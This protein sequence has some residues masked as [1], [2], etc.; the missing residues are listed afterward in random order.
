MTCFCQEIMKLSTSL[1]CWIF[2]LGFGLWM[3]V[4]LVEGGGSPL[5]PVTEESTMS[6]NRQVIIQ[7]GHEN[8]KTITQQGEHLELRLE[9]DGDHNMAEVQQS[10]NHN[11]AVSIQEGGENSSRI[12]QQGSGNRATITQGGKRLADP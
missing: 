9:Q 12:R 7:H 11:Q 10:G 2:S 1:C 5:Q 6:K 8:Q 4:G 3:C